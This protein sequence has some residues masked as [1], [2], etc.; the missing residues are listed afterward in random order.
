MDIKENHILVGLGGTGGKI[1]KAFRKRLYQKYNEEE[2]E[3]LPIGFVYVDSSIEMMDPDDVTWRVLGQNALFKE[4]EF[5]FIKG[6][7]PSAVLRNPSSYPGLKGFIGNPEVMGKALGE[8]GAAAAQK[9]IAGRILFGSSVDRYKKTLEQ[10]F[11]KVN[12]ISGSVRTNIH[13]FTG[14]AGGT[15]SGSIIDVIAQTRMVDQFRKVLDSDGKTGTNIVVYC[16]IPEITPPGLSDAGRYHANGY[17]ALTEINGLLVSKYKPYDVSGHYERLDLDSIRKVADGC[18]LYSNVNEHGKIIESHRQLPNI[19]SD[20]AYNRIFLEKNENTEEFIRTYSFEN[21]SDW[22]AEYFDKFVNGKKEIERSKRFSSFGIKRIV[23]PE[24]EMIE[25]FTYSFG[26]Q[27]LLQLRFNNWNDDL[28]F[29]ETPANIDFNSF[30]TENEQL[31]RWR[32]TDKHIILDK[33]ILSSDAKKWT[34]IV[35]YWSSV[36]PVWTEQASKSSMPLNELEKYCT[37]GYEKYF[38]KSGVNNFYDNKAQAKEEHANEIT[39]LI[40][41]YLFDKWSAGDFSLYNLTQLIDKII[42]SIDQRRKSFEGQITTLSQTIEQLEQAKALNQL[43]WANLGL[44]GG[45]IKKNKLIQAHSTIM[46]QLCIKKTETAGTHFGVVLLAILLNK[47]NALRGRIERFVNIINEALGETEKQIGARCQDNGNHINLQET[48]IRYYNHSEVTKFTKE[49]IK[50]KKRQ[51]NIASEFRQELIK[52]I[53]NEHSFARANASIST[54]TISQMLDTVV[55]RK[56]ITIHDEILIE[57]HE[58]IINRNILEQLNEEYRTEDQLRAFAKSV[59]EQSGVFLSFNDNELKRA[60]TGADHKLTPPT[61]GATIL[62]KIVFINLPNAEGNEQI[63]KFAQKLKN[64]LANAVTGGVEVYVDMNGNDKN[65]ITISSISYCFPLRVVESLTFL[66]EKYDR[67]VYN[68]PQTRII[69]HTEGTGEFL[70]D[71]FVADEKQPSEIRDE[72]TAYL[73]LSYVLGIVKYA[74]KEDGTGRSAYGTVSVN[75]LGEEILEPIADVFTQIPFHQSF[76]EDFGESLKER[77]E[78][79]LKSDYIHIDK[80]SALIKEIQTLYR[81]IILPEFDGNKGSEEC[82][83]FGKKAEDAMDIIEKV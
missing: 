36:I 45:L 74:S 33:P 4:N 16:M 55:R 79:M 39:D 44:I 21:I 47:L 29:R 70:P 71:L 41:Q 82:K 64:A 37:E 57:N 15:G 58:K 38:R 8:V 51:E 73:I 26:R 43:E 54:D 81:E 40:E 5:V 12:K 78:K 77:T 83:F 30:V 17:A 42:E 10:Q 14:L 20:F 22:D 3:K 6:V 13:I 11:T 49:V 35:D 56:T 31:E 2:R 72:Y 67:L 53:G 18:I 75:R 50:D 65:E 28:G 59:I 23:I 69:L 46:Q 66:K 24:E 76:T 61:L 34:S 27:A 7:D 63:I 62:R 60:T 80:K 68:S 52:L 32:I 25:Y 1:L 19:V 48:V 9:R